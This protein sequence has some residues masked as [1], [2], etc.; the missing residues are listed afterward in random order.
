MAHTG[1][2]PRQ[3]GEDAFRIVPGHGLVVQQAAQCIGKT[4][5]QNGLRQLTDNTMPACCVED[6]GACQSSPRVVESAQ[7]GRRQVH[8]LPP[9]IACISASVMLM[10]PAVESMSHGRCRNGEV[11]VAG[12]QLRR[13]LTTTV[14]DIHAGVGAWCASHGPAFANHRQCGVVRRNG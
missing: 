4:A 1:C 9:P 8:P 2:L 13:Y 10:V 3:M 11:I 7:T 5:F 12:C 6:F 14:D